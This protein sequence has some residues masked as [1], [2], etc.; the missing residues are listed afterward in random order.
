MKK[1][2]TGSIAAFAAAYLCVLALLCTGVAEL[3]FANREASVSQKE[4]RMLQAFP[5][6]T[7]ENFFSGNYMDE[8]ESWMSDNIFCR[9]QLVDVSR[10]VLGVF[11]ITSEEERAGS[12]EGRMSFIWLAQP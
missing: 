12:M 6:L 3:L 9:N 4:N 1:R 5:E 8:L 7:A 10:S 11:D 2:N